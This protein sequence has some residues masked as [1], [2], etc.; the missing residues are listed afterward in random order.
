MLSH[1]NRLEYLKHNIYNNQK[2]KAIQIAIRKKNN[3]L[4]ASAWNTV[5][6]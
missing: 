3:K 4:L 2:L 1:K 5:E 6:Q